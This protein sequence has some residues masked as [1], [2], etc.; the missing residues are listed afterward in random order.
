MVPQSA[1]CI[2]GYGINKKAY[3]IFI[4]E[5]WGYRAADQTIKEFSAKNK[6]NTYI[7]FPSL[8][9]QIPNKSDNWP[10]NGYNNL[11]E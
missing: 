6:L 2:Y 11:I 1:L 8:I 5:V 7:L 3:D 4:K 9:T 10:T